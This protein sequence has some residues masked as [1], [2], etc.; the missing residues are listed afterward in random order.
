MRTNFL[1]PPAEEAPMNLSALSA[2]EDGRGA[3]PTLLTV[4]SPPAGGRRPSIASSGKLL[5]DD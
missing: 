4:G 5:Y 3:R 1:E 2:P